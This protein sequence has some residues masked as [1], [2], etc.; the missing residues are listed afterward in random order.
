MTFKL[1]SEKPVKQCKGEGLSPPTSSHTVRSS[2]PSAALLHEVCQESHIG[3][4]LIIT[5]S[6]LLWSAGTSFQLQGSSRPSLLCQIQGGKK[7]VTCALR[8]TGI[9]GEEHPLMKEFYEKGLATKRCVI[10]TIPASTE[11]G[12][13]YVGEL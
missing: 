6:C 3:C 4:W 1:C 2:S 7:L 11:H 9:Y 8:P 5:Q 13:V 12:R 10:R